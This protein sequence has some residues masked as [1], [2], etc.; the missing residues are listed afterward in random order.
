MNKDLVIE[1]HAVTEQQPPALP[2]TTAKAALPVRISV[3]IPEQILKQ[4]L[5]QTTL[6][7]QDEISRLDDIQQQLL[8]QQNTLKQQIQEADQ[9]IQLKQEQISILEQQLATIS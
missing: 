4:P 8:E 3:L 5:P 9:L 6:L 2:A 7:A 1:N